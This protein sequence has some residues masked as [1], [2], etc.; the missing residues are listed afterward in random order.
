VFDIT[1][2][3]AIS[4]ATGNT[5][6]P[7]GPDLTLG[8]NY[9]Y[10]EVTNTIGSQTRTIASIP[11][12]LTVQPGERAME[13]TISSQPRSALYFPTETIRALEV[14]AAS[15]DSGTLSYQWFSNTTAS[16]TGGSA[17][18]G[19]TNAAFTPPVNLAS[20]G[21]HHYYV[22]VTNTNPNVTGA[23]IATTTS[24][25]VQ[26]RVSTPSGAVPNARVTVNTGVRRNYIRGYG[27]MDVAWSNFPETTAQDTDLL[28]NPDYGLGLNM[29]RIMI[30]PGN[31]NIETTMRDLVAGDRP[32]FYN[33]VRIANSYGGSV[34]ASPWSPPREWKTNNSI[35]GSGRLI[36]AYYRQ[37]SGYLRS[38]AQH[39]FN[40]GAPIYAISIQN[41]P[42]YT[43]GYDGALWSPNE[44]RD[45][46]IEVGHF[47]R[48]VRG[49]GG[50]RDTPV[51]L[52]MIGE[53]A[54]NPDIQYPAMDD[55]R[56]RAV[57]DLLARHNYGERASHMD[58][59]RLHGKEIWMTE[60]N[61]NGGKDRKSVV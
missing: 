23:T 53:S 35:D 40:N 4:G 42:N 9:Y 46:F 29:L 38:F 8:V 37:Y 52:T 27:A 5:F 16:G 60:M 36:P 45:F 11:A 43:A 32:D 14:A 12:R 51:V 17:I 18:L 31:I 26:V 49:F 28:F 33:N 59:N 50:G 25:P 1:G 47:T 41:E 44:M 15:P 10:V 61:I 24:R 34:L 30:M 20:P 55:A 58:Q 7:H 56:S 19:E 39:M 48:G 13:P 57:I 22:V 54:N 3:I 6:L 2:G 21:T